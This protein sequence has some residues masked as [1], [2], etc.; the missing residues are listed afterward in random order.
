MLLWNVFTRTQL[1]FDTVVFTLRK[2]LRKMKTYL[3]C[4]MCSK[5]TCFKDFEK[6]KRNQLW[7]CQLSRSDPNTWLVICMKKEIN[8]T[9]SWRRPLSF[10][11]QSL[12]LQ[13]KSMDWFLYDNGLRHERVNYYQN[14]SSHY[15]YGREFNSFMMGVPIYDY[16][17]QINRLVSIW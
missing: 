10:R 7:Y 9:L 4:H 3:Y 8:L 16:A 5:I 2:K 1:I 13:S 15:N 14:L 17:L 6:F 12:D 11:N